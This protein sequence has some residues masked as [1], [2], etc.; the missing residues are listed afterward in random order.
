M[1]VTNNLPQYAKEKV[2]LTKPKKE[3]ENLLSVCEESKKK[4]TTKTGQT[5]L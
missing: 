4:K 2:V 5:K 1:C 3:K